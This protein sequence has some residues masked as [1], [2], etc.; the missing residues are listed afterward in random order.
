MSFPGRPGFVS[1][2]VLDTSKNQ[3]VYAHC[4]AT[5]KVFG[6][7][8]ESNAYRIRT[9]HNRDPRGA[10]TESMLPGGYMTTSFRTNA[11]QKKLVIHRAKSV[12]TLDSER[13]CRTKLIADVNGDVGKLFRQWSNFGWHRVTVFG[14]VQEPIAEFGKALGLEVVVE[15]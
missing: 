15:A 12:G 14:D 7:Q 6:S 10:C 13:G 11:A 4:V 2:P 1:D 9:L 8:S 5:T 3:I